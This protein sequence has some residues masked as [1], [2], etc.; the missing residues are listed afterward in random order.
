[1]KKILFLFVITL[2][3]LAVLAQTPEKFSYQAVIRNNA[4]TLLTNASIGMQVSILQGSATGSAVYVE[5]HTAT[6]NA[7]GLVTLNIGAG[8]PVSGMFGT[9][10][11]GSGT[12]YIKTET[13][14]AGG[15]NY[16][17]TGTS[18]LLSVPYALYAINVQNN[19]DADANPTNEL[20][21]LSINGNQLTISEG[22]TV[23]LP[24]GGTGGDNWGTQV[25][26]TD[27]TLAG[28]G[29]GASPLKIAQ[30]GAASGQVLKWNGTSWLPADDQGSAGSN[31]TGPAGGDLSGTYP[32]P[33]VAANAIT[34]AKIADGTV[35]TSDIAD[36]AITTPKLADGSVTTAKLADNAVTTAKINDGTIG[37]ADLANNAVTEAK[38]A[39]NSVTSSKIS[40]GAV[41][42]A[43]VASN[44]ITV[45]KLPAGATGTTYLRGDGT[46]ATPPSGALPGGNDGNL[47]FKQGTALAGSDNL[48]WNNTNKFLK[49]T[50]TGT[51]EGNVLFVGEFKS[52]N[53]GDP[54]ATGVGTR[55][56]WYPD[57]AALRAGF[58]AG[59]Q[60]DKDNIGVYS[61]AMGMNTT[62]SGM[63]S[64]A[65]GSFTNASGMYS[66]AMGFATTASGVNSVA[67][68]STTVAS[69]SYTTAMGL[70]TTASGDY[71]TALGRVTTASGD[72]STTTG[73]GTTALGNISTAM[74]HTT[75][76]SGYA[77][78][79][80]GDNTT[81]SGDNST[82]V[83]YVTTASGDFSTAMGSMTTA[84]SGFE[85]AMGRFNTNYNYAWNS[86]WDP[87]DRLLV[88]GNGTSNTARS[89]ALIIYKNGNITVKN[90]KSL[91]RFTDAVQRKQLSTTVTVNSTINA[92][93]TAQ[94]SFTFPESFT[95]APLVYIGNATGGGFAEVVMSVANVTTTGGKL[96]VY[97]PKSSSQ[98]PNYTVN[99]IALGQE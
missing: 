19:D 35:A 6:S 96:F 83:G 10:N 50:G 9:I 16:S 81:A 87:N 67:M 38:L 46:W 60:W 31:P 18:Q 47:Q 95:T 98:T 79:A 40:D 15:V 82:A 90:G 69:G 30:Q 7:N 86:G 72:Y 65:M 88:V 59:A 24:S 80:I 44:A 70:N 56:M 94:I 92:G 1:M 3:V 91:L 77:S 53:P 63:H 25:A 52:S 20:Q 2:S 42:T 21:S 71:S 68:G 51:G 27:A 49:T 43:E 41:N 33:L 54:P 39:D 99:V 29:L 93:A 61:T 73:S 32:N 37:T 76:A 23:T 48:T 64:T 66:I 4:N 11:W 58:V 97:N 13:D 84:P 34:T 62:A 28:D 8:T 12:Y 75:S 85:I 55:M 78:T 57:K 89:D 22:N 26:M 74:G 5:R 45:A 17:I 14:P 36:G